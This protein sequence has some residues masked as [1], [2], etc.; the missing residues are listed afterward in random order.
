MC[1][2]VCVPVCVLDDVSLEILMFCCVPFALLKLSKHMGL[3]NMNDRIMM[4]LFL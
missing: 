2:P 3:I 1:V 4:L